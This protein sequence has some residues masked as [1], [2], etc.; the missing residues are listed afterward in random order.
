M[1][2]LEIA[3][4]IASVVSVVLGVG[5]I[6]LS[7]VFYRMSSQTFEDTR[8]ASKGIGA[9]VDRLEKLF[10]KLY[11]DTFSIMRDTVSDMRKHMWPNE[12]EASDKVAIEAEEKAEQ[13][14]QALRESVQQQLSDLLKRQQLAD[15]RL[16]SVTGELTGMMDRVISQSRKAETEAVKE[17]IREHIF[18][19]YRMLER[20]G[21]KVTADDIVEMLKG[22]FA[23]SHLIDELRR[24]KADHQIYYEGELNPATEIDVL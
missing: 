23:R 9:S 1:S 13:K 14:V 10:D 16:S 18:H 4:L 12:S 24:M 2:G 19:M 6:A 11:A 20:A 17:T 5:A 21:K 3:A 7:I 8:D 22:R 15:D